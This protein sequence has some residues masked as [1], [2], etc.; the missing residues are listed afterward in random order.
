MSG[1][2]VEAESES[3]QRMTEREKRVRMYLNNYKVIVHD[4]QSHA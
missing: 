4:S 1:K 3:G 2:G